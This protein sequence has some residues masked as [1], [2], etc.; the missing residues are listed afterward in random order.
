MSILIFKYVLNIETLRLYKWNTTRLLMKIPYFVVFL[1]KN[2]QFSTRINTEAEPN[3]VRN[4]CSLH[5]L[6]YTEFLR[7]WFFFST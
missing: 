2:S 5:F 6:L 7:F 3:I 4:Q 1:S